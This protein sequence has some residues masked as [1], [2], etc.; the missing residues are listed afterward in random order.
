L[1]QWDP[2]LSVIRLL[3]KTNSTP[4]GTTDGG[5]IGGDIIGTNLMARLTIE[6]GDGKIPVANLYLHLDPSGMFELTPPILT[7]KLAFT[8]YLLETKIAQTVSGVTTYTKLHRFNLSTPSVILDP[9]L[10]WVLQVPCEHIGME[11]FDE[12]AISLNQELV[13]PKVRVGSCIIQHNNQPPVVVQVNIVT[14]TFPDTDA[15]K[16]DYFPTSPQT[17]GQCIKDVI[18]RLKQDGPSGGVF[19]NYYFSIAA[20]P[21]TT[22]VVDITLDQFGAVDSGVSITSTTNQEAMLL[23]RTTSTSNKKR[24]NRIVVRFHPRGGSLPGEFQKFKSTFEHAKFRPEWNGSQLYSLGDNVKKTFTSETPNVIRFFTCKLAVTFATGISPD[25]D[26]THWL[27]D[28]TVIPDWSA[29]AYY[30]PGEIV[31]QAG[32]FVTSFYKCTAAVGPSAT[33]PASDGAHWITSMATRS[34]TPLTYNPFFSPSPWT[35]D[36]QSWKTNLVG[37]TTIPGIYPTYAGAAVDW[38]YERQINDLVDYTNR[39]RLVSGKSVRRQQNAP[40]SGR[41][42]YNGIRVLVGTS[43]SGAFTGHANQVAEYF[44]DPIGLLNPLWNFSDAPVAGDTIFV[45]ERSEVWKFDGANWTIVWTVAVSGLPGPFHIVKSIRLCKSAT[46][47]PGQAVEY[48]FNWKDATQ[49]GDNVNQTSRGWWVNNFY[50]YPVSDNSSKNIGGLYGGDNTHAPSNSMVD[51]QN[52]NFT[53]KGDSGWNNGID[54]EEKGRISAHP[55]KI[56]VGYWKST[57]ESQ[58]IYGRGNIPAV[59]WRKDA[60]G[61]FFFKDII[62]PENGEFYPITV[63][64]PPFGPTN[65]YFNRLNELV[66]VY[67]YTL[68]YDFFIKEK[69]FSGVQYDWRKNQAWGVFGK[70]TYNNTGMYQGCYRSFLDQASEAASQIIPSTIRGLQDIASGNWS[71]LESIAMTPDAVDHVNVAIDELHYIHEGYA[72]FPDTIVSEPRVD[73]EDLS[74][75]TDYLTSKAFAQATYIENQFF[76]NERYVDCTGD[77]AIRYGELI[78]ET[79]ARVPG[80]TLSSVVASDKIIIDNKGFNHTLY[81]I[82]KFVI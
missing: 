74:S 45:L 17:L 6:E 4:T 82:R 64:L 32:I 20:N 22:M 70:E 40:P 49:G 34:E 19:K 28:F 80:G 29:D 18:D 10:G 59:Y 71:D 36:L 58:I 24:R 76:P 30:T 54:D 15:L 33:P 35:A 44:L 53:R 51:H 52:L 25:Q 26:D 55:F 67:G 13:S 46:E 12:S 48:R 27:E 65:I 47:I 38:N 14:N 39:F 75:E 79:D 50:P 63:Q 62:I 61:R 41:E 3:D 72:V 81:L 73:I 1:T 43:P 31:T 2:N 7:D 77:A 16:Q 11:A 57:D 42:L 78:T 56:R 21:T 37:L 68:P 60:N 8:K 69:E 5:L 23:N 66:Q 9:D